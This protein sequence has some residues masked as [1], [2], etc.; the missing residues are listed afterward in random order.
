MLF[1][2]REAV[3]A[4]FAVLGSDVSRVIGDEARM[5]RLESAGAERFELLVEGAAVAEVTGLASAVLAWAACHT[6]FAQSVGKGERRAVNVFIQ[7]FV[8]KVRDAVV[9]PRSC[10][11]LAKRL[12]VKLD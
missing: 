9:V 7:H 6:V 5:P 4:F 10:W 8:L 12:G 2:E 3:E 1:S 11:A